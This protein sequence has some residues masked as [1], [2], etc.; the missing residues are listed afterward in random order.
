MKGPSREGGGAGVGGHMK[1]PGDAAS[2]VQGQPPIPRTTR[3]FRSAA[4][5]DG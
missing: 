1:T 5:W 4:F 2:P 3:P